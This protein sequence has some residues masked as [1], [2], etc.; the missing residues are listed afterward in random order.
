MHAPSVIR[1]ARTSVSARRSQTNRPGSES[2][3]TE[4]PLFGS[5]VLV[6]PSHEPVVAAEHMS[7]GRTRTRRSFPGQPRCAL[8]TRLAGEPDSRGTNGVAA[9][10]RSR[11]PSQSW[12]LL[13]W[14][15]TA[16]GRRPAYGPP[17][18]P[19]P[20]ERSRQPNNLL[21]AKPALEGSP[22]GRPSQVE[23]FRPAGRRPGSSESEVGPYSPVS[24]LTYPDRGP[25]T[26]DRR[27]ALAS[28]LP[29]TLSAIGPN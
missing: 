18:S 22:V 1:R 13:R 14:R 26:A 6:T 20:R 23:R 19:A 12:N 21:T 25:W 3:P 16:K 24:A 7:D 4:G 10:P 28:T 17:K 11:D 8:R 27:S 9:N 15:I 29:I 5:A 2:A